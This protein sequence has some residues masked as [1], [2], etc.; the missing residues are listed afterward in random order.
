MNKERVIYLEET[1]S[2]NRYAETLAM[3]GWEGLVF[4]GRQNA[5]RGR[6]DRGFISRDGGLYMSVVSGFSAEPERLLCFPL[7]A[8]LAV[9]DFLNR[10]YS[11]DTLI[12]WPNDIYYNGR[13][14][15]GIL[16]QMCRNDGKTCLITGV[17]VNLSNG[18]SAEIPY[19]A[20]LKELTGKEFAAKDL[21]EPLAD[22]INEYYG[23]GLTEKDDF[24]DEIG[25]R[26]LSLG[27]RVR[28]EAFDISGTAV[29]LGKYG[30]LVIKP[31]H[32]DEIYVDFG[33][34]VVE[35]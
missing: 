17:G 3:E 13:K 25:K 29:R 7:F 16:M 5:G 15:C 34:V 35:E 18:I 8:A 6:K 21:A 26:C 11:I 22:M 9:S 32:G 1:D 2:T 23:R 19:A 10:I 30:E 4:A 20:D 28:A 31:D 27:K 12:K 33:D 14:V 24:L